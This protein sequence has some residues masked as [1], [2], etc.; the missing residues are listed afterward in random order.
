MTA[1]REVEGPPSQREARGSRVAAGGGRG[2]AGFA[3]EGGG[4][5]GRARRGEVAVRFLPAER[6]H[7]DGTRAPVVTAA[8]P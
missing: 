6:E 2:L 1:A 8:T 4:E 5:A 7:A 3:G